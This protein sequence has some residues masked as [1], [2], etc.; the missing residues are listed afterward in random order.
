VQ[1]F[2]AAYA[3]DRAAAL[4]GVP[5][6][7]VHYWART[8]LL[9]PSVS[10]DRVKLW[11]YSDVVALRIIGWLR[12]TKQSSDGVEV[13]PTRIPV[14]RHALSALRKLELDLWSEEHGPTVLIDRRGA[15]HIKRDGAVS[16]I[17][18]PGRLVMPGFIDLMAPFQLVEGQTGPDL[19]QPRPRL[20]IIPGKLAGSLTS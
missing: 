15:L 7:T 16:T 3:A 9:I 11:S 17:G 6:S 2:R 14:V 1:L 19:R 12:Q 5:K 8:E 4:A 13:P 18:A 10:A 20:R